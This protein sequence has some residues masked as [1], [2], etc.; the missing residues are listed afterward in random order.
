MS[1]H[2]QRLLK[3][4]GQKTPETPPILEL[5]PDHPLVARLKDDAGRLAEWSRLLLEEAQLAE[6]A[7]L[8]DPAGFVRRV[9]A[10]LLTDSPRGSAG[11][12]P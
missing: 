11:A 7:S 3:S 5:N 8:A 4:A 12:P 6:G 2:L 1:Q 10:L 9:N